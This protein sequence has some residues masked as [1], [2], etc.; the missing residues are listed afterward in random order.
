MK[1]FKHVDVSFAVATDN[2]LITPIVKNAEEKSIGQ[3]AQDTRTLIEKSKNN[4]LQPQDY[5][6][7][8]ITISNLGMMGIDAFSAV[9]NPPQVC[10]LAISQTKKCPVFDEESGMR[11]ENKMNVT[12]SADHRVVDGAVGA[13]WLAVFKKYME[14]PMMLCI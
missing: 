8:T 11:W 6:G 2:G 10:I 14:N 13:R 7:G 3:I 12:L 9:I 4:K 5:Q 1:Q